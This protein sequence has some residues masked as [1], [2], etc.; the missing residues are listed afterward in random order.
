MSSKEALSL[1]FNFARL[2]THQTIIF[3]GNFLYYNKLLKEN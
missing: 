2:K 1:L 3:P